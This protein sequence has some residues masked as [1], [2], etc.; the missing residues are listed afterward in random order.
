LILINK[1]SNSC[2]QK[3]I[4][5]REVT[6]GITDLLQITN[7]LKEQHLH[8]SDGMG[9][10]NMD[11]SGNCMGDMDYASNCELVHIWNKLVDIL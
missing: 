1:L 7:L 11:T 8:G 10:M 2:E 5:S 9:K 6:A 3:Y 4:Q